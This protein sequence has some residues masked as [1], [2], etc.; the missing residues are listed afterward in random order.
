VEKRG[1]VRLCCKVLTPGKTSLDGD[2]DNLFI[3]Y[4]MMLSDHS[5]PSSAEVKYE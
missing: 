5:P 1:G 3:I 4:L 2:N